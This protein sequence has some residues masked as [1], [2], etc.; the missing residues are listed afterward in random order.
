MGLFAYNYLPPINHHIDF[1]LVEIHTRG[2]VAAIPN[3]LGLAFD[4]GELFYGFAENIGDVDAALFI[5]C[6]QFESELGICRVGK[7][8]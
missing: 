5:D 8:V 4:E 1:G 6:R 2:R 3:E 7:T